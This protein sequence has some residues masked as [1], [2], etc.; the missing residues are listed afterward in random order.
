MRAPV[1]FAME[2]SARSEVGTIFIV[3]VPPP[4]SSLMRRATSRAETLCWRI[5]LSSKGAAEDRVR[6][7]GEWRA[8][9]PTSQFTTKPEIMLMLRARI[10]VLKAKERRP[11]SKARSR[12]ER[13]VTLTSDTWQVIPMMKEKYAKSR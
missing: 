5:S 6:Y 7:N 12:I 11:W 3:T 2:K 1:S 10:T 9:S 13:E 4:R 8:E